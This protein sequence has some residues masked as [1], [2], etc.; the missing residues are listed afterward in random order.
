MVVD[1]R[2]Y[3]GR[4]EK[5]WMTTRAMTVRYAGVNRRKSGTAWKNANKFGALLAFSYLCSRIAIV[6]VVAN[7]SNHPK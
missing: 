5:C 3:G 1:M 6:V 7:F 2:S 4:C